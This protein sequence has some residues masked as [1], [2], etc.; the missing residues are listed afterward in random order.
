M[1][2]EEAVKLERQ[3]KAGLG[4]A[5]VVAVFSVV[6]L[7]A[8]MYIIIDDRG[9]DPYTPISVS[10]PALVVD[11]DGTIPTVDGVDGPAVI[12]EIPPRDAAGDFVPQCGSENC[13]VVPISYTQ[14]NDTDETIIVDVV[15][16]WLWVNADTGEQR[17][18]VQG[19]AQLEV[20]PGDTQITIPAN[21]PDGVYEDLLEFAD[22]G[23]YES[24]GWSVTGSLD[25]IGDGEPVEVRSVNF[26]L[27]HPES[28]FA[29]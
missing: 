14:T 23:L 1:S 10:T 8:A 3:A 5:L 4:G 13:T 27:V 16:G 9:D 19:G 25:P 2:I 11:S 12:Y 7:I 29:N 17:F 22:A 6:T 28:E 18:V 20:L 24:A 21:V 26:T 15:G